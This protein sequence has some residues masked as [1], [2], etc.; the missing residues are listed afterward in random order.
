M[1]AAKSGGLLL[2]ARRQRHSPTV[3]QHLIQP[4]H[5]FQA[6]AAGQGQTADQGVDLWVPGLPEG[7]ERRGP[8]GAAKSAS[9]KSKLSPLLNCRQDSR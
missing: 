7:A 8:L 3:V 6:L 5:F 2:L 4:G 9:R 1:G